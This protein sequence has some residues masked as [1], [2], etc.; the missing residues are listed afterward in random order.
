MKQRGVALITAMLILALASVMAVAIG[1]NSAMAAR[2]STAVFSVEQGLQLAMG[3][4]ALAAF[5][6]REDAKSGNN[7]DDLRDAWAQTPPPFE[8][9][10]E[11]VLEASLSDLQ[12]RFNLNA[13]FKSDGSID[14]DA[15][16]VFRRLLELLELE[17]KWADLLIDWLDDNVLSEPEGGEDSLYLSQTVPHRAANLPITSVSELMQLPGFSRDHYLKLLPHVSALPSSVRTINVC[18]ATGYVLDALAAV[19]DRNTNAIE[20]S[21]LS[22]ED[23]QRNRA[24]DCFPRASVLGA[25]EARVQALIGEQSAWFQ[26]RSWARIG[27]TEL[28]LYS[29]IYRDANGQVRPIVRSFGTD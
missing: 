1:F 4:E 7:I 2:R 26:L 22:D 5:S 8:I 21:R 9:A 13:V 19:S 16:A 27:T 24:A 17:R 25:N 28:A 3:A 29:L 20:Y 18:L 11:V 23:W 14:P 12:G 6:L 10:P 15:V